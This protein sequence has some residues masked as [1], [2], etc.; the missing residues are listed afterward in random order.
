MKKQCK[1]PIIIFSGSIILLFAYIIVS[2]AISLSFQKYLQFPD[3]NVTMIDI[4]HYDSNTS[5]SIENVDDKQEFFDLAKD[6]I[7]YSRLKTYDYPFDSL[8]NTYS[9]IIWSKDYS[10]VFNVSNKEPN[11]C[12]FMGDKFDYYITGGDVI[13]D[14][15]DKYT[16]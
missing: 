15:L 12:F 9:I 13:A 16:Q 10:C 6:N 1:Y 11:N 8:H 4:K 7:K 2:Y 14:Y 3:T 5:F